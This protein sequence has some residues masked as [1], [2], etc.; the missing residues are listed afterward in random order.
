MNG[1]FVLDINSTLSNWSYTRNVLFRSFSSAGGNYSQLFCIG[2]DYRSR[3]CFG[4]HVCLGQKQ[5][6]LHLPYEF[7][8]ESPFLILGSK[9]DPYD[10]PFWRIG[11]D[12]IRPV[13]GTT[14]DYSP[15]PAYLIGRYFNS[16]MLWHQVMDFLVP[17]YWT[18]T[19]FASGV[20][21]DS[22]GHPDN[23]RYGLLVNTTN[24]I[25][26]YDW[27]GPEQSE[28]HRALSDRPLRAFA[29]EWPEVCHS[30]MVL[31]MR[32]TERR[33]TGSYQGRF[34]LPY[35]VDPR[36]V[37][38]FREQLVRFAGA[39]CDEPETPVVL[40]VE[41][42]TSGR[43]LLNH[44]DVVETTREM[45]PEC[46]IVVTDFWRTRQRD[47]I[48]VACRASVLIGIHG[49][50]LAHAAWMKR[51]PVAAVIEFLP[52]KYDCRD[53]YHRM[54]DAFGVQYYAVPTLSVN[55]S[56]WEERVDKDI[57][58]CHTMEDACPRFS[59]HDYLRDQSII[60]DI[61]FYKGIVRPFFSSLIES[62][63]GGNRTK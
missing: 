20:L 19:S 3:F 40:F 11:S 47:Q 45:C 16:Q 42:G 46:Q 59:C 51:A 8:F 31:G 27:M 48:R 13:N 61:P 22:W 1:A 34:F 21:D 50:G 18:M 33:P 53:W 29:H 4:T 58:K 54:A 62:R 17:L 7:S 35:E 12:M 36:G 23:D 26:S 60:V 44:K 37:R 14:R 38:W 63:R 30:L 10:A 41:R 49:S 43:R 2:A 28:L 52:Y 57:Q 15:I 56:R 25:F 6:Q 39:T 9:P 32:K 5:L 55:Q 24:Q